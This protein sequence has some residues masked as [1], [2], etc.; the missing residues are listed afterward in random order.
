MPGDELRRPPRA[1]L[2]RQRA[3]GLRAPRAPRSRSGCRAFACAGSRPPRPASR[4]STRRT[5]RRRR[6]ARTRTARSTS[7]SRRPPTRS[8]SRCSPRWRPSTPIPTSASASAASSHSGARGP[9]PRRRRTCS[10][11]R[12]TSSV[13]ASRSTSRP[14]RTA[15][16]S[17]CGSCRSR[18]AEARFV[19]RHGVAEV[20]GAPAGAARSTSSTRARADRVAPPRLL[21]VRAARVELLHRQH[22]LARAAVG[23]GQAGAQR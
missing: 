10:S 12:R 4:G 13:P 22:H 7:C 21:D 3:R 23:A 2:S 14:A 18:S 6:W 20:R 17:C 19:R 15:A 8:S 5:A 11:C 1:R 16:S 9:G